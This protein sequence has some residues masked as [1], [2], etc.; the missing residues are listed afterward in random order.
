MPEPPNNVEDFYKEVNNDE[1]QMVFINRLINKLSQLPIAHVDSLTSLEGVKGSAKVAVLNEIIFNINLLS[2]EDDKLATISTDE[3][4]INT[5][6]KY[7]N[8]AKT[9][10]TGLNKAIDLYNTEGIII[11][12]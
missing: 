8:K 12:N 11:P 7:W 6:P 5:T 3:I 1:K 9:I 10:M 4:E 2:N